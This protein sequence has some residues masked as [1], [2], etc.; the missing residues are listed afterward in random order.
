MPSSLHFITATV[1][2]RAPRFIED[3]V[4]IYSSTLQILEVLSSWFAFFLVLVAGGGV[5]CPILM[6][7]IKRKSD[8][9]GCCS[10]C[11]GNH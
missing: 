8:C 9:G 11:T 10:V 6:T 2:G 3:R 5:C 4:L 7:L 1:E